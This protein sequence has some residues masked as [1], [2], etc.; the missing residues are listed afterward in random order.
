[1]TDVDLIKMEEVARALEK[2]IVIAAALE[3]S[4][5]VVLGPCL[6]FSDIRSHGTQ[7]REIHDLLVKNFAN[8]NTQASGG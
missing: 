8:S 3:D 4:R 6:S 1:M 5:P 2:L 7:L